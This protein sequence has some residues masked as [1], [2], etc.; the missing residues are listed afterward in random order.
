[1][2]KLT[3]LSAD[4]QRALSTFLAI[5]DEPFSVIVRDA[6]IQRFEYTFEVVWK[7]TREHMRLDEGVIPNSPK[8]CFRCAFRAGLLDEE[9]TI[10]ALQMT[11]DRNRTVHTYHEEVATAI[12]ARLSDYS[13]LMNNLFG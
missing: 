11:D 3:A 8:S 6:A 12:F 5:L 1:M 4:A 13:T 9:E 7:L 10:L 2:E